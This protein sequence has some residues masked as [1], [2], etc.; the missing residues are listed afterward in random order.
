MAREVRSIRLYSS[1]EHD[2]DFVVN[3][4]AYLSDGWCSVCGELETGC[5]H[6]AACN[7]YI[8]SHCFAGH[9][10]CPSCWAEV[11]HGP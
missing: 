11:V 8:H 6:C 3:G 7:I 9:F 2:W 5:R 1:H 10:E 4:G